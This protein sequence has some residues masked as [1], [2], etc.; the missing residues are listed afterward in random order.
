MC[1][2]IPAR[3]KSLLADHLAEVDF[4]GNGLTVEMGLT[5]AQVGDY[6]LVHAGCAIERIDP[7]MAA[8]IFEIIGEIMP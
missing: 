4:Q 5:E 2:A 1:L 7:E 3:V 6:V 8:E